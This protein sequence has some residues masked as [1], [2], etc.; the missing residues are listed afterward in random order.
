MLASFFLPSHL[1]FK[2]MYIPQCSYIANYPRTQLHSSSLET[3]RNCSN[4]FTHMH[5]HV[6]T[7]MYIIHNVI[8]IQYIYVYCTY[9]DMYM[10]C[11]MYIIHYIHMY[12]HVCKTVWW[13]PW[14]WRWWHTVCVLCRLPSL[15][16]YRGKNYL[17]NVL[18][19]INKFQTANLS[20]S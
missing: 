7:C 9:I 19:I 18:H 3:S 10:Y 20:I 16:C 2:N 1:S 15:L 4:S 14:R 6:Y 11:I 17:K 8:H 12:V 5:L 13:S